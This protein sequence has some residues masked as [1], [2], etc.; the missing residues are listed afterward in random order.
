METN[1]SLQK[2]LDA[3]ERQYLHVR[4][5]ENR[6]YSISEILMLPEISSSHV[7]CAEWG[8]RKKSC[9]RLLR[10]LQAKNKELNILEAGCGNGWL[11][12]KMAATINAKVTGVD[13]NRMELMQAVTAFE[14]IANLKFLYGDLR[15]SGL[16]QHSFDV[17]LFASSV[18]YFDSVEK[19]INAALQLL[20]KDGEI[21]IMDTP[22]YAPR[23]VSKAS[24]R[25][26]EYYRAIGFN[27]MQGY[28]FH[29]SIKELHP[30]N[31]KILF[32]PS[33]I[34]GKWK[35]KQYPFHWIVIK[36]KD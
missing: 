19:I 34:M 13:I 24:R 7:H 32:N 28:Y 33:S 3:F 35:K 6:I 17:I 30:Y 36:Q 9:E 22:F 21:H 4:L 29:H 8:I 5:T 25:T 26:T 1:V 14:R 11:A 15:T 18:Q 12:A 20:K 2:E 27:E 16:P 31:Y 10:F 23:E